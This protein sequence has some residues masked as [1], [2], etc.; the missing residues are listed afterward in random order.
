MI[1]RN[2]SAMD[3]PSPDRAKRLGRTFV[4]LWFLIGGIAH[5]AATDTEV[6]LVPPYIPW[7]LGAVW[8]SGAFELL[9]AGGLLFS[10][11][12]RAAGIGLFALTIC[13]TPVHVY[14]LQRP[15][16]FAVP[17][18]ALVLRLPVQVALLVLIAWS[19]FWK[20]RP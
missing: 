12:R 20:A 9:G 17:Y 7:P 18:W 5:F 15:E 16:L 14:M 10:A 8:V 1:M 4:F 11:T 13:V 6:R 3:S 2:P 19:T